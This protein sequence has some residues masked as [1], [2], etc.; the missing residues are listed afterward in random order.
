M[1]VCMCMIA[2]QTSTLCASLTDFIAA[3]GKIHGILSGLDTVQYQLDVWS[4]MALD[5]LGNRTLGC[6]GVK[7]LGDS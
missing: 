3:E 5:C 6:I 1:F 4:Y 7:V 2:S